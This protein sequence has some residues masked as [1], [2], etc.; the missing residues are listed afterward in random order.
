[1]SQPPNEDESTKC[2]SEAATWIQKID[3]AFRD[4][5]GMPWGERV[6]MW[7]SRSQC[8]LAKPRE[9]KSL[10]GFPEA[11]KEKIRGNQ[12]LDYNQNL[13]DI[14]GTNIDL[15][16][17]LAS[18]SPKLLMRVY[19]V[20]GVKR[21]A[22]ISCPVGFIANA[23]EH[24]LR[25]HYECVT[26]M[27][28]ELA[29]TLIVQHIEWLDRVDDIFLSF[30]NS[31]LFVCSHA[32]GRHEN[33]QE[34]TFMCIGDP[35]ELTDMDGNPAKLYP[36]VPL[37]EAVG[38]KVP[39]DSFILRA[40]LEWLSDTSLLDPKR[41]FRHVRFEDFFRCGLHRLCP[42]L[43]VEGPRRRSKL[44]TQ[45]LAWRMTNLE[46]S[47]VPITITDCE[48]AYRCSNLVASRSHWI[49]FYFFAL[50]LGLRNRDLVNCEIFNKWVI[51]H[52]SRKFFI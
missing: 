28:E 34:D 30:T 7:R 5:E 45:L 20:S 49:H 6:N 24:K 8:D 51:D 48:D 32:T 4:V 39:H 47:P 19:S 29:K 38:S 15:L 17:G 43:M 12:I 31:L 41:S 18:P 23:S 9:L 1:M 3:H 46:C 21:S 22:G 36:S 26:D 10:A 27:P 37:L 14:S 35:K 16:P 40:T 25:D 11:T 2:E 42:G 33:G 13:L 52:Y 44:Y 50:S